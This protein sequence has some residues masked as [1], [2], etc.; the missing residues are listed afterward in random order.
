MGRDAVAHPLS[1]IEMHVLIKS[2]QWHWEGEIRARA[3]LD[4]LDTTGVK[5]TE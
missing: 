4:P 2:L 1:P 3:G 5:D